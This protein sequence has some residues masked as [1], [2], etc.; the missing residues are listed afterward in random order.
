[1]S[2]HIFISSSQ[3]LLEYF[4][5]NLILLNILRFTVNAC[6]IQLIHWVIGPINHLQLQHTSQWSHQSVSWGCETS[7]GKL[8]E[9]KVRPHGGDASS[10]P[11]PLLLCSHK[12]D[13]QQFL[14]CAALIHHF[15]FIQPTCNSNCCHCLM[16]CNESGL[17]VYATPVKIMREQSYFFNVVLLFLLPLDCMNL[18]EVKHG[19]LWSS[20]S[21]RTHVCTFN[22]WTSV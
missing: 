9:G 10:E 14:L 22:S 17:N 19:P 8:Q 7:G 1:M 4:S 18:V 20:W 6:L 2:M 15:P 3:F 21:D 16:S 11:L 12:D 5:F 13:T